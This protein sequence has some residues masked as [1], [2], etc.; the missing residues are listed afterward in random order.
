[1]GVENLINYCNELYSNADTECRCEDCNNDC[2]G[3]CEK[4][5]DSIHFG[6]NRRYN[7]MNSM[8]YYVCKY[9]YKY[10]SEIAN[11]FYRNDFIDSKEQVNIISIGCGPCTDLMGIEQYIDNNSLD[12]KIKYRGIDLN[13][14]W[15]YI[16]RFIKRDL[17]EYDI[18]FLYDDVFNVFNT[19]K[20][21]GKYD[22]LFLQYLIS[23]MVKYNDENTMNLFIDNLVNKIIFNM[24]IGSLVIIN[25]INHN[26]AR[27]YY[28]IILNKMWQEGIRYNCDR[29]HF[30]NSAR[31]NHY[32]YGCEYDDND[33]VCNV[34][35]EI[36]MNYNP[37]MFC[38]SA[39][40]IIK[41]R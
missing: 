28:E 30:N 41:R 1:M 31:A 24:P 7:C 10:L 15:K 34:P 16:H 39:Q 29:L 5:L 33:L 2:K 19:S 37:W 36:Q 25:D 8:N 4:C 21:I 14:N 35:E 17:N 12:I 32:N 18:K 3:S 11:I 38:S 22:I 40:L 23:D 9:S 13:D 6:D 20:K 26:S 27:K